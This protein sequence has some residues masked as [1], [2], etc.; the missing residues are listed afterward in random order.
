MKVLFTAGI[1]FTVFSSPLPKKTPVVIAYVGG[2]RGLVKTEMIEAEKITHINYAFVNIRNGRAYLQ[3]EGTDTVNFLNLIQLKKKNKNL[4]VLISLGGWSWSEHF[5][6]AALSDSTRRLF[7][8]S[9]AGIVQR[10]NLDGIDIDWEYPGLKGEDN[11]FRAEDRENFTLLLR[12][13]RESLDALRGR[14]NK[15][16]LTIAS[17]GFP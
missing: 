8:A 16:Q 14:K 9:A 4:K 10:W 1:V 13:I 3:N 11:V 17:G 6:D 15:Y 2:Y 12:A 5:S 7:A